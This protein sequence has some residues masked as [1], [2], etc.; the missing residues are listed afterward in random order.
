MKRAIV[1]RKAAGAV[2]PYSQG[3]IAHCG[4]LVA[5]AGQIGI[6]PETGSLVPGG[7]RAE[8]DRAMKNLSAILEEG[9]ASL[10]DVVKVTVFFQNLDDFAEVNELYASWFDEPYPARS[11]V[12]VTALPKGA[13]IEVEALAVLTE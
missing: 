4:R 12:E 6:D 11:A 10:A 9:G 3:T 1:T 2:G 13:T 8:F 5:T 7:V